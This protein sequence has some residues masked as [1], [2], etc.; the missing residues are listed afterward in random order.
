MGIA[1]TQEHH[2]FD[3]DYKCQ[4]QRR[5]AAVS[6]ISPF[7]LFLRTGFKDEESPKGP[8]YYQVC[9]LV[10]YVAERNLN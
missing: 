2:H 6:L 9:N 3:T 8:T 1:F 5:H 10:A 4:L 7:L